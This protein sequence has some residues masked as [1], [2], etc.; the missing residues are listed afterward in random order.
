M[1]IQKNLRRDRQRRK[2]KHGMQI[3]GRSVRDLWQIGIERS[4]RKPRKK[5]RKGSRKKK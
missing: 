4:K 2:G 3:C 1:R 5:K